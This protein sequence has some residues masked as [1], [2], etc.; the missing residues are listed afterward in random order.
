MLFRS[1][2]VQTIKRGVVSTLDSVHPA[3]WLRTRLALRNHNLEPELWLVPRLLSEGG[4]AIDV[5][6]NAGTYSTQFARYASIVHAFEPNPIC[7]RQLSRILPARVIVHPCALSDHAGRATLRFDPGNT[8][9]GT[10]ETANQLKDNAGIRTIETADVEIRTLDS[11]G[12]ASV[13]LIK[14][15]AEGHEEAVLKGAADTLSRWRPSLIVEIE[16]RHNPG[17]LARIRALFGGMG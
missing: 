7:L 8:G 5:G 14:I 6:A 17:G 1:S 15:D 3:I 12:F 4:M 9:I 10:I 13:G 2:L 16:E 11:F